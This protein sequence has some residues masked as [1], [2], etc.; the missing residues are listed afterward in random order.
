[1]NDTV[2]MVAEAIMKAA[3]VRDEYGDVILLSNPVACA[4]A[5]IDAY[6][7]SEQYRAERRDEM[8]QTEKL[9]GI[10]DNYREALEYGL[11]YAQTGFP[12]LTSMPPKDTRSIF[13]KMAKDAL[14]SDK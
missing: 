11:Q 3:K 12:M 6:I 2:K 1:M 13:I 9:L 4:Q 10:I 5:A 7:N 14:G 8:K